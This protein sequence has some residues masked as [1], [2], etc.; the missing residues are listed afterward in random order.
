M[1][2]PLFPLNMVPFPGEMLN[3]HIF[4]PRYKQLIGECLDGDKTFGIP[5]YV[6][7]RIEFGTEMKIIR[8][9]QLYEDG[10]MDISTVGL[11]AFKV[12]KFT[13]QEP[14]KLYPS[15]EVRFI[16]DDP[17]VSSDLQ[18]QFYQTIKELFKVMEVDNQVH[19]H[20]EI[21]SFDIAHKIGLS[22]NQEY[23][24]LS[25]PSEQER[26]EFILSHIKVAIP[27]L[28]EMQR[29][30]EVIKMNGHFR[31]FNPLEL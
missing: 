9:V 28:K 20:N 8:L 22:Q 17:K 16:P 4:E 23:K 11:R 6:D 3:L 30:R 7:N 31:F 2:L 21:R 18:E 29:A 19:I 14:G 24:L 26:Q 12:E 13:P 25:I 5:S 27:I 10:R 1:K 15:G